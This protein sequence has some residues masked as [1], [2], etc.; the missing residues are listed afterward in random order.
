V[1]V[2]LSPL[3]RKGVW[4]IGNILLNTTK[5]GLNP[6]FVVL[7]CRDSTG[8]AEA[9]IPYSAAKRAIS[10]N[11]LATHYPVSSADSLAVFC[12][13]C[14]ASTIERGFVGLAPT[15]KLSIVEFV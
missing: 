13:K 10:S 1:L 3:Y 12:G 4:G 9:R 7:S 11:I 5:G 8:E 2:K 14:V 6:P 15:K